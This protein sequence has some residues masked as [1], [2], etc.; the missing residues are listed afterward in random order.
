M[1]QITTSLGQPTQLLASE[2]LRIHFTKAGKMLLMPYPIS[3]SARKLPHGLTR[4]SNDSA[5]FAELALDN[6][7]AIW[8]KV[9]VELSVA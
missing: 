7:N 5:S 9:I 8:N 4:Y 1:R 6:V 2:T 3:I